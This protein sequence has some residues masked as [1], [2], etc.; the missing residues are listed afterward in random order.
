MSDATQAS[1]ITVLIVDDHTV[2][3]KGLRSLLDTEA[4]LKVVGE[5]ANGREAVTQAKALEPDV[6]LMD[7]VMPE[8]GGTEAI[9]EIVA[10]QPSARV[11]VL[12]SF[13]AD[14]E[15]FPALK[16]GAIGYLLKD[17]SP[18][19]LVRAIRRTARGQ[20]SLNPSIARRLLRELS[21][22]P[23]R[24]APV[25]TLSRRET[26]VLRLVARGMTND[27]IAEALLVS[28]A[29]IR[30]HVS[31]VL[32]KLGLANRTQAALYALRTGLASLEDIDRSSE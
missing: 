17:T 24:S 14:G 1:P 6:I 5:A 4:D 26:E 21:G 10:T 20:S 31:N 32:A 22:K 18:E 16:A 25:E 30:T 11:L 29:T 7:L 13:G 2:V 9:A 28:E 19:D 27:Q 3:R 15:L 12:T 8:M 23:D